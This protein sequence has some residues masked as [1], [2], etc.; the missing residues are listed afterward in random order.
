MSRTFDYLIVDPFLQWK[1]RAIVSCTAWV[2]CYRFSNG[3]PGA[4]FALQLRPRGEN[5]Y[6]T[7]NLIGKK[8]TWVE[9][10]V[11]GGFGKAPVGWN[12]PSHG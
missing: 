5:R 4:R 10:N 7:T 8:G 6:S 2:P 3:N 12:L 1:A 11:I 9:G